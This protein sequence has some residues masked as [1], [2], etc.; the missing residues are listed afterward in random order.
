MLD[1]PFLTISDR[2]VTDFFERGLIGLVFHPEYSTNGLFY[3]AY[4]RVGADFGEGGDVV[5]EEHRVS[6]ADPNIA[7]PVPTR[8]IIVA[9]HFDVQGHNGGQLA[10][11][12][13]GYL[14]IGIG[15]AE[16]AG[17]PM[18]RAEDLDIF[19]GKLLRILIPDSGGYRIPGDNPFVGRDGLDEVWAYGL[20]NP[21]RFS[22][23]R[24]TGDLYIADVGEDAMEEVN[25]QSGSSAGGQNYGWPTL[26]GTECSYPGEVP[27]DD[28]SFTPPILTYDRDGGCA[29]IGGYVYR[30]PSSV[31]DGIYLY[32]DHCGG[33]IRGARQCGGD[34]WATAEILDARDSFELRGFTSF[35]EG[36][37]GR[38]FLADHGGSLFEVE[39]RSDGQ[40]PTGLRC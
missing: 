19:T 6:E 8:R 26:E 11:G 16:I 22:F 4:T 17:A 35:G 27:C 21:W 3:V 34:G 5:V 28:P 2:V 29:V 9:H 37:D 36:K 23:D 38:I 33:V 39:P 24:K 30:G 12:P 40:L 14:Y 13:D 1:E 20:R 10:F 7:D 15:D 32:T 18:R 25:F 31:I